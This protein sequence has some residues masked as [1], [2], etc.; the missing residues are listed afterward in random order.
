M[1][2]ANLWE[3]TM[4]PIYK[5]I[6]MT[7]T[8]LVVWL[9]GRNV[10]GDG[11]QI[12]DIAAFSTYLSCFVKMSIKTSHRRPPVQCRPEGPG[13]VGPHPAPSRCLPSPA[14]T[15]TGLSAGSPYGP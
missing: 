11:W 10:L 14:G 15:G 7:G 4:Q 6:A 2:L 9:G 8:I 13:I 5:I 3:N 12:W 1:I